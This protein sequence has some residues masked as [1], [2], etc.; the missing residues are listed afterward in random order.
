MKQA[1]RN[2]RKTR[3]LARRVAADP[4][5]FPDDFIAI[6]LDPE[7]ISRVFSPE[8]V[9]LL[10]ELREEGPFASVNELAE[11]LG[12]EQSRV[13]RDLNELMSAGLVET[14]RKGKSKRV[15]APDKPILLA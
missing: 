7:I 1:E 3:E 12:R 14:E 15:S 10:K 4:D 11:A 2:L 5:A 8:R 9:R 6:P 13:S